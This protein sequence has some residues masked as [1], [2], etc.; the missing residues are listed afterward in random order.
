MN[1]PT[2]M[3]DGWYIDNDAITHVVPALVG[4]GLAAVV[5]AFFAHKVCQRAASHVAYRAHIETE[6]A[7]S[8]KL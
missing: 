4:G 3:A 8:V 6:C 7:F 5:G 1:A 2:E